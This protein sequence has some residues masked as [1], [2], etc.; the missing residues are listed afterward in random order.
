MIT[1]A[2]GPSKV[3]DALPRYM[4]DAYQE[5]ILSANHRSSGFMN[6]Y[7][8]TEQLMRE[9]LHMPA[10][11]K[12]LFTSSA[13]ENWEIISQ[14]IVEKAS[15]HI[16][17]GSFGKKWLDYAKYIIPETEG[18][19]IEANQSIE[20]S[21]L[22]IGAKLDL[23]AITQN[24]TANASQVQMSVLK[25]LGKKYPEK[26]IAVDT[27]SSMGGIALDFSLA[28]IWYASVQKCFGMPAGLGILIVS[29]KA[30]EKA[31]R[32]GEKGRYNS[33][34][35]MLE[36]AA[37]YQTHYTPN[38]FGIYLLNRVL[39]DL[40]DI[41]T[42]DSRLRRRMNNLESAISNSSKFQLLVDNTQTRSTTVLAVSGTEE[43]ISEVKKAAE[44]HGM[45]LGSGYGPLKPTS[46]RI[47]NF[48][49]ITD[50][51]FDRL[52]DFLRNY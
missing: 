1:F 41:Q 2:P 11:Y 21:S 48:P 39:K 14:S 28:D 29:P 42:V 50:G 23:I 7:R 32:K 38:V 35:F 22:E 5:G 15:F 34:S 26:M 47:A 43:L 3:Y 46:F 16:Y 37:G 49:A 45:Q 25:E 33:L 36:N 27:T 9:K 10:D 18:L 24:E 20:L 8:D 13:T 31:E 40:E 52:I 51:E 4:Q 30:I 19:K 12:L 44:K 17:S 6:L